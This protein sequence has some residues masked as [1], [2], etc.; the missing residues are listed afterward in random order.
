MVEV[1]RHTLQ[2]RERKVWPILVEVYESKG[3]GAGP[4]TW[5]GA[6]EKDDHVI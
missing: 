3:T 2:N 6:S 4:E 5:P 1:L